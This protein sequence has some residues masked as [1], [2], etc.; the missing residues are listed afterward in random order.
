[1]PVT[2]E[3]IA[4]LV[5]RFETCTL[6]REQWTHRE[7]L[8]IALSYLRRLPRAEAAQKIRSGI[9][10]FNAAVGR[11]HLYHETITLAWVEIIAQFLA[12]ND[13]NQSMCDLAQALLVQCGN[14]DYLLRF[15]SRELLFSDA[16]R[17]QWTPPD[18][19]PPT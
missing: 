10:R 3:F 4:S 14:R 15:Y 6:P 12:E 9:Q 18:F 1:M 8:L 13:R 5:S 19:R 16:A 11:A 17:R 2:D 7:H